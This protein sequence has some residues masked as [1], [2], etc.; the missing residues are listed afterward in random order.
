[1]SDLNSWSREE[2]AR[3]FDLHDVEDVAELHRTYAGLQPR[4]LGNLLLLSNNAGARTVVVEYRY[5]DADYR[6]E[7]TSFYSTTYTRYP[8]VAHRFHFF[9]GLLP[10]DALDA[11]RPSSFD[12]ES[13][14]GYSV[15]RPV[16]T[17]PVGRTLLRPPSNLRPNVT[18]VARDDV[19]LYGSDLSVLGA[20]FMGQDSQLSVCVHVAAWTCAYYHHLRFSDSPRRVV[21]DISR[22]AP[23]ENSRLV[24]SAG[25]TVR[26]LAKMLDAVELPPVVYDLGQLPPKESMP[27]IACRYLDSGLPV[28][29]AAE[30]HAFVLVGYRWVRDEGRRRIQFIRQD[31]LCG[32]Y[33]LVE[34]FN[35]D[36]Y[37]PWKHLVVPLPAKVYMSG[38][39][40]EKLGARMIES[41]L[42][43]SSHPLC[44]QILADLRSDENVLGYRTSVHRSNELKNGLPGRRSEMVAGI[45]QWHW[46]SRWVWVVEL[47]DERRWFENEPSVVAEVLIDA[48]GHANGRKLLAWRLPG[49]VGRTVPDSDEDKSF[50]VNE[51]DHQPSVVQTKTDVLDI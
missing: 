28:I 19:N 2:P 47:V 8:S 20:P 21:A 24:P 12:D 42:S 44:A 37:R 46:M 34:N 32:G 22:L 50:D 43:K 9:A 48:T 38:E 29:V 5:I 26:Q 10:D 17:S 25:L 16:E 39:G 31:D 45:F 36:Q 27:Q 23:L 40:A 30:R 11:G 6:S 7:H 18:C 41:M 13:Y 15:M 49:E 1:M 14:L 4:L 33:E 3:Q 51:A 35:L